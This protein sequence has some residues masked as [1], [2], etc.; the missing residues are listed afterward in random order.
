M[1]DWLTKRGLTDAELDDVLDS[2]IEANRRYWKRLA[3]VKDKAKLEL[4]NQVFLARQ[5]EL[6][7]PT[8]GG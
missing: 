5:A 4:D 7:K 3:E 1:I 6:T 8:K 2:A